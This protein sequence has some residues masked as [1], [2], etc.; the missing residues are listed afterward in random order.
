MGHKQTTAPIANLEVTIERQISRQIA[1]AICLQQAAMR[2]LARATI[3][4]A[5]RIAEHEMNCADP[6]TE[7]Q[8]VARHLRNAR[9]TLESARLS[10]GLLLK[11][12]RIHV[13]STTE[14]VS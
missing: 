9:Y 7:L 8:R 3:R 10:L 1:D 2:E 14:A 12:Q 5:D 6:P 4:V 13:P 11:P